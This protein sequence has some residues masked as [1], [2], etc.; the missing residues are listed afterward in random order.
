MVTLDAAADANSEFVGWSGG[1]CTGAAACSFTVGPP[2]TVMAEFRCKA[3]FDGSGDVSVQDIFE[4]L[5]AWFAGDPRADLDGVSGI[6]VQD[7]F[8]FLDIWFGGC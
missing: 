7:I 1:P 6:S 4:Y 5:N 8:G 3:D 2:V